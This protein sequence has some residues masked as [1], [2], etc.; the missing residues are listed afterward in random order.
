VSDEEYVPR[1]LRRF[2]R[3]EEEEFKFTEE[4]VKETSTEIAINEVDKFKK[5]N[6][7][8]P[9][10]NS[11]IEEISKNVFDQLKTDLE[12]KK[13]EKEK[14]SENME[15]DFG[16]T[17][18]EAGTEKESFLE[19]R[20]AKRSERTEKRR[21]YKDKKEIDASDEGKEEPVV[22]E[23]MAMKENPD[24][25]EDLFGE[26]DKRKQSERGELKKLAGIDELESLSGDLGDDEFDLIEKETETTQNNCP[27]CN[28][29]T[30]ELIYCPNCGQA[31]C[32]H[33]AKAV[34]VLNDS[35]KYTC[36]KC[37]NE[38]KKRKKN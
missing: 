21:Q 36:P 16:E 35:V 26:K 32:D 27:F 28:S 38:F 37:K 24:E 3:E 20:K 34:E 11:E 10:D 18:E 5:R 17:Q 9:K 25:I 6:D 33:C 14:I 23:P 13:I 29:K 12:E 7:R 2:R 22:T 31:F 30:K 15:L 19:K 8:Y 4:E 1:R